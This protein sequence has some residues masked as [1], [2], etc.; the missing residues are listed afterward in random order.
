[1]PR[2]Q[3]LT[4]RMRD[5][6]SVGKIV[7][8]VELIALA[9]SLTR[10]SV[11]FTD[12]RGPLSFIDQD[13]WMQ[14]DTSFSAAPDFPLLT[15]VEIAFRKHSHVIPDLEETLRGAMPNTA[16]ICIT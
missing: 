6:D 4:F 15:S 11:E 7:A 9:E 12:A 8:V 5:H 3:K 10:I 2:L 13:T 16:H 1:M 14:V